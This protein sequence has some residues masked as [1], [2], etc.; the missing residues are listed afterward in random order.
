MS[1]DDLAS[2][3]YNMIL[4]GLLDVLMVQERFLTISGMLEY[5]PVRAD[6]HDKWRENIRENWQ[7][8][9]ARAMALDMVSKRIIWQV[10]PRLEDGAS[11]PLNCLLELPL[12]NISS[13]GLFQGMD[14][15]EA[16]WTVISKAGE[17][18]KLLI[19]FV[20]GVEKALLK[21]RLNNNF[22]IL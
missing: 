19:P 12:P 9:K 13:L 21:G 8:Q 6:M 14:L 4:S 18:N 11:S 17:Y 1:T 2:P 16:L 20:N 15:L 7:I 10:L 22:P 5:V 3:E